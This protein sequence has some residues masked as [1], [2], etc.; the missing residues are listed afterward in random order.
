MTIMQ[1]ETTTDHELVP[2]DETVDPDRKTHMVAPS[3][4]PR[5]CHALGNGPEITSQDVVDYAR[6]HDMVV[7]AL[8]GY[9]WIPKHRPGMFSTCEACDVEAGRRLG[10]R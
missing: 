7:T 1:E 10:G 3:D 4:N 5:I 6:L 8:C 2:Y 9:T